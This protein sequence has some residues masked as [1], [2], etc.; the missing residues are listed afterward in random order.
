MSSEN[1]AQALLGD[2]GIDPLHPTSRDSGRFRVECIATS[3]SDRTH[4]GVDGYDLEHA[5]ESSAEGVLEISERTGRLVAKP[6]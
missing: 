3:E 2:R 1:L 6:R 5:H 4:Q